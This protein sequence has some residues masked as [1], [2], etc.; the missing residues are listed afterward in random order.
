MKAAKKFNRTDKIAFMT[1][2]M[3]SNLPYDQ[4]SY[5]DKIEA[6]LETGA[7][8]FLTNFPRNEKVIDSM[9]KFAREI[10]PSFK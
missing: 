7:S 10:M 2:S 1:A 6:A 3:G 8:Y 9:R 5:N 4:K